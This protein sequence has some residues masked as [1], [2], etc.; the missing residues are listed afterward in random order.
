MWSKKLY[1][2]FNKRPMIIMMISWHLEIEL[3]KF[4]W[5]RLHGVEMFLDIDVNVDD[6]E[7]LD[8]VEE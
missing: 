5:V 8:D 3:L 2:L 6:G 7:P 1:T 4:A